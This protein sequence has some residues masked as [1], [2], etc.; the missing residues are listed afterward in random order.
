MLNPPYAPLLPHC[1]K[2]SN[3]PYRGEK[4]DEG[5]EERRLRGEDVRR[6]GAVVAPRQ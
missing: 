5:G 4:L 1:N 3:P 6:G 2:C